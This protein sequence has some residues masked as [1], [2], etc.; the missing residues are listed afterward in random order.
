LR[1]HKLSAGWLP[2]LCFV[3]WFSNGCKILGPKRGHPGS[4]SVAETG[5]D[6]PKIRFC[7]PHT[8]YSGPP[9]P[10]TLNH[11]TDHARIY[12][13]TSAS[14]RGFANAPGQL[15]CRLAESLRDILY[16]ADVRNLDAIE[17]SGSLN[18]IGRV[19][20]LSPEY[21]NSKIYSGK[22][23]YLPKA[24]D[25]ARTHHAQNLIL[26]LTDGVV[27]IRNPQHSLRS[28]ESMSQCAEGS[29]ETCLASSVE[30]YIKAGHG[31]WIIGIRIPFK[32]TYYVEERTACPLQRVIRNISVA[33]RPFYVWVGAP[34][35][36]QGRQIV[37][38]LVA[39][40][41]RQTPKLD[42][43]SIEASPGKWMGSSFISTISDVAPTKQKD[44]ANGDLLDRRSYIGGLPVLEAEPAIREKRRV[45]QPV[46]GFALPVE[47]AFKIPA[48]SPLVEV[49]QTLK[50]Q[51]SGTTLNYETFS[52]DGGKQQLD[53]CLRFSD[54]AARERAG[55][56]LPVCSEWEVRRGDES[57]P[58]I[59]WSSDTDCDSRALNRTLHLDILLEDVQA[60][61]VGPPG[62]AQVLET[63][64][65]DV[66]YRAKR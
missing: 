38:S 26:V 58:W 56:T 55:T 8:D 33:D 49:H 39:F 18:D 60:D 30:K 6:A 12:I 50:T 15:Y 7:T 23:S 13:D 16:Q 47:P 2:I 42:S 59:Q 43:I 64:V 36:D 37:S 62:T 34:S 40:A 61:L 29:D 51:Q 25:D 22:E 35:L 46:L 44:C 48:M 54:V 19:T 57:R 63:T 31:F 17:V 45:R 32:G 3:A 4:S 10:D 20:T 65:L 5:S 28:T 53:L 66:H 41:A 52:S 24:I 14:I 27:S 21:C 9:R 11:L 1:L